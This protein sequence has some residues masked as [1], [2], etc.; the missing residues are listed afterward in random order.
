MDNQFNTLVR[1]YHDNYMEY[2]VT[3]AQK[4][5]QAYQSAEQGIQSILSQLQN[6]LNTEKAQL[7][8]FYKSG[9][10]EKLQQLDSENKMLQ[11]G[12]I[13]QRDETV[14]A[15]MRQP[16]FS[17]SSIPTWQYVTIGGLAGASILL[18]FL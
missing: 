3:G 8:E 9:V 2:K 15:Q 6:E 10:Q 16:S 13:D 12:L 1:S 18:S 17:F 7:A 4:Y 14:G 5:Q 11:R